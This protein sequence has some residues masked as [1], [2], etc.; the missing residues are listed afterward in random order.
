[1]RIAVLCSELM[2]NQFNNCDGCSNETH[3]WI[4]LEEGVVTMGIDLGVPLMHQLM[5]HA[6]Y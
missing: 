4:A 3:S 6:C 5:R 2:T 1:M